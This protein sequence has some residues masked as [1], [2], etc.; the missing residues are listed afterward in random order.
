MIV[1]GL[2]YCIPEDLDTW[3]ASYKVDGDCVAQDKL[4]VHYSPLVKYVAN[5]V[6]VGMPQNTNHS[7]LVSYGMFGLLDALKKF[8]ISRKIKF[9]T[10]AVLR[11]RGA[12]I[13]ELRVNDWV[14]RS[15]RKKARMVETAYAE[16]EATLLCPPTDAELAHKM[17][18]S[19]KE[20]QRILTQISLTG[21]VALDE[22]ISLGSTEGRMTIGDMIPDSHAGPVDAFETKESKYLLAEAIEALSD[23]ERT[24]LT[25]YYYENM[26]LAEI[27]TVIGVTES[28]VCQIHTKAIIHLKDKLANLDRELSPYHRKSLTKKPPRTRRSINTRTVTPRSNTT[29]NIPS[30][31]VNQHIT[32]VPCQV[33][34]VNIIP[35]TMAAQ[36]MYHEASKAS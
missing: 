12:I 35:D 13:D 31:G 14:P 17:G 26:T 25:L 7:D 16:L 27:G 4:I 24:V 28:R 29:P 5:R 18:I 32:S 23:K 33:V 19:V 8:D 20:F 21:V 10:Y 34:P 30:M 6:A 36:H 1:D 22:L 11:I 2:G 9:E 15:I 3:W